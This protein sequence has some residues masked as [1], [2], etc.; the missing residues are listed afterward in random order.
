MLFDVWSEN[1]P[2]FERLME[3]HSNPPILYYGRVPIFRCLDPHSRVDQKSEGF[4][5]IAHLLATPQ[6]LLD[7]TCRATLYIGSDNVT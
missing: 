3:I 1:A 7:I 5:G 2:C 6:S 4:C